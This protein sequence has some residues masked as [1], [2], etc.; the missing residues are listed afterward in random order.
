MS[1][2]ELCQRFLKEQ[3]NIDKLHH[4]LSLQ[5]LIEKEKM[6]SPLVEEI[7][8]SVVSE[9]LVPEKK[10]IEIGGG[11]F[12]MDINLHYTQKHPPHT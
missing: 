8:E 4:Q 7:S 12:K 1:Q 11:E 10:T 2:N 9:Q 3:L 5:V 6:K